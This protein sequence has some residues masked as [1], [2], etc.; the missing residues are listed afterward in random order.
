MEVIH[1]AQR[2]RR[3][4]LTAATG[5]VGRQMT[6]QTEVDNSAALLI[7]M[8]HVVGSKRTEQSNTI[9]ASESEH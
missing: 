4:L 3:V 5:S 9:A 1:F 6:A 8:I 2:G 7:M